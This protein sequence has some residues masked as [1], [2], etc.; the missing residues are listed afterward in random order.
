MPPS[1][2]PGSP[3]EPLAAR[4]RLA[5]LFD[6]PGFHETFQ[7]ARHAALLPGR[8]P[9]EASSDELV[10]GR[11]LVEG[12]LAYAS[13][14][15]GPF[16]EGTRGWIQARAVCGIMDLALKAHAPFVWMSG[17]GAPDRRALGAA[18]RDY[19]RVFHYNALLGGSV[20]QIAVIT[21][22]ADGLAFVPSLTDFV[23]ATASVRRVAVA[24][25]EILADEIAAGP[26][27]R[28]PRGGDV[29]IVAG[30]DT[31]AVLA[32]RRLL[33]YVAPPADAAG[34]EAARPAAVAPPDDGVLQG[35]RPTAQRYDMAEVLHRIADRGSIF[36]VHRHYAPGLITAFARFDGEPAA[37]VAN[38]PAVGDGALTA[39]AADK[40]SRFVRFC[41]AHG[42]PLVSVVDVPG[43][44]PLG[45][46]AGPRSVTRHAARMLFAFSAANVPKITVIVG[47]A[48]GGA[49][50]A[51]S[52][53]SLGADRVAAW[54]M[55]DIRLVPAERDLGAMLRREAE[56]GTDAPPAS[57]GGR[58]RTSPYAAAAAGVVDAVI[59][60]ARTRAYIIAALASLR[61][62]DR[63]GTLAIPATP[64][65]TMFAGRA[66]TAGVLS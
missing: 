6:E 66:A 24:G 23:I 35:L 44:A 13:S 21:G 22:P 17:A 53:K 34:W 65:R 15:A 57:G 26:Q 19:A 33:S 10:S 18:L 32:A 5:V 38:Q 51:M 7:F 46:G 43:F 4:E 9:A 55:A 64:A 62:R 37:L 41:N 52:A 36:A 59:E 47:R 30:S 25:A 2:H 50:L 1:P 58:D 49:Y 63:T 14:H 48:Y 11:G 60:P 12:R 42:I 39:E 16:L 3:A 40:A 56:G 27:E 8:L 20:P 31:E 28:S 29:H 61:S 54:P 45:A